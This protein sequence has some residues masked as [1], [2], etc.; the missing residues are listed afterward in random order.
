MLNAEAL[1]AVLDEL[2][3]AL[4]EGDVT[5]VRLYQ[6]HQLALQSVYGEAAKNMGELISCFDF[7]A[8]LSMLQIL[9]ATQ[10]SPAAQESAEKEAP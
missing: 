4:L 5:V 8:A 10:E 1:P 2:Q 9:R 6:K 3:N 7:E